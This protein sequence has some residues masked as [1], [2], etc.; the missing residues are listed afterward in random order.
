LAKQITSQQQS[1]VV[2]EQGI[3]WKPSFAA[4]TSSANFGFNYKCTVS[5]SDVVFVFDF[6]AD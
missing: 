5:N 2:E 6:L 3:G 1:K 4:G